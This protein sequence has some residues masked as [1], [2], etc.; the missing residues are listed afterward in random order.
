MAWVKPLFSAAE[1]NRAGDALKN[2]A[3]SE[4]EFLAATEVLDNWRAIHSYP[5]HVF[6]IRLKNTALKVD[7]KAL[8]VQRLKRVPAILKKLQRSY[9]G[10][11]ATMKLAQMQDIGGCRA[12]LSNANRVEKLAGEYYLRGDIRHK[13]VG[14]KNY[15]NEPKR[16]GYRSIHLVYRFTSDKGKKEYNDLLVEIQ[17]RSKLQHRWA[18]AVE[19][20]DFFT[21]QAI[22]S[23]EGQEEWME[24]FRLVSSAFARMENC[25]PV[26]DTPS[27]EKELYLKI[28][29]KE[30]EL[31][32]I[33][34]MTGW[35]EAIGVF[36]RK[37]KQS[38]ELQF[39]LLE[40][41]IAGEKLNI[42]QYTKK[43]EQKAIRDY[44]ESENKNRGKKEYDVVLVGA[45]TTNDLKKAYPNYFVDTQEFLTN[46]KKIVNKY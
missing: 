5:M 4:K 42:T 14:Y 2:P 30:R 39:F 28:K 38:P 35:T 33:K 36:E 25:P 16:D 17:L 37:F 32:V 44:A 15:I 8:V 3:S 19:T 26:P 10:R 34:V 22:K 12:V 1:V 43:D 45:D 21:R 31:N 41:D 7:S 9:H 46:L 11:P 27:D 13:R 29:E 18:T 20:V 40:L 24:F 23:N 6:K